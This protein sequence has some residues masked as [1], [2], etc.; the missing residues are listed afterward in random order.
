MAG[1]PLVLIK[2]VAHQ[3]HNFFT[4]L[5]IEIFKNKK[6]KKYLL[7]SL[8]LTLVLIVICSV[9]YPLFIAAIAKLAP[10]GGKGETRDNLKTNS[11]LPATP[12]RGRRLVDP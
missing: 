6:M 1:A 10:G 4:T 2:P 12:V 5:K 7:P 9:I 11:M 8:K 3:S